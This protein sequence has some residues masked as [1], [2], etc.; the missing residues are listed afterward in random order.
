MAQL[1]ATVA[2][3]DYDDIFADVDPVAHVTVV[4]LD[5]S[6]TELKR[7]T[8]LVGTPGGNLKPASEALTAENYL[9]IL[10]EDV[11]KASAGDAVTAYKT[12]NFAASRLLTDGEY[13]LVDAD[14]EYLRKS[15]LQVTGIIELADGSEAV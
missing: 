1:D 9:V 11:A 7:G 8:I 13:E 5:E 10:A 6:E 12:G 15:G 2:R 14:L 3:H 4:K